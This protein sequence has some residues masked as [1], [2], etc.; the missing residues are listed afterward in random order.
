MEIKQPKPESLISRDYIN[1]GLRHTDLASEIV[2]EDDVIETLGGVEIKGNV[3]EYI[4]KEGYLNILPLHRVV[5]IR[6]K[7]RV[8]ICNK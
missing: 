7:N 3:V 4:D 2:L 8:D 1:F 6:S 5:C